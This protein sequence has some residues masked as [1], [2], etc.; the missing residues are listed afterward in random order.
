MQAATECIERAKEQGHQNW[1]LLASIHEAQAAA[2]AGMTA[3]AIPKLRELIGILSG[4]GDSLGVPHFKTWLAQALASERNFEEALTLLDEAIAAANR[5]TGY[6]AASQLRR[7]KGDVLLAMPSPD[8]RQ[9]EA[10]L[11]E[12]I[13]IARQQEA[14]S[15]ELQAALSLARLWQRNGKANEAREM[16]KSI[17]D[18]F[19]E[20]FDTPDLEEARGLL[21][22]L[23]HR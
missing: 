3:Q 16:L 4:V 13:D 5:N 17:Y 2:A 9:A 20:G 8:E 11:L 23:T 1:V 6:Y 12:A 22:R 14:K 19:T 18:W 21:E 15:F 10:L 7:I